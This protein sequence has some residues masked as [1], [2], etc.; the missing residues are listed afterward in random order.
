MVKLPHE[1]IIEFIPLLTCV[2]VAE[3]M[4]LVSRS[5]VH[6]HSC[7]LVAVILFRQI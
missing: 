6:Y 3:V 4:A 1:F 7:K 5:L 2:N